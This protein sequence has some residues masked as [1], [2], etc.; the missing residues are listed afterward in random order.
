MDQAE[1][2]NQSVPLDYLE[3]S[4]SFVAWRDLWFG[5]EQIVID[6]YEMGRRVAVEL[7][8]ENEW[9]K[10]KPLNERGLLFRH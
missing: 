9:Q 4:E 5:K 6:S 8:L 3:T 2:Y 1:N 10:G 7:W